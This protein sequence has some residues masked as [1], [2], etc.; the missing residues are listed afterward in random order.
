MHFLTLITAMLTGVV[1]GAW[2]SSSLD[3]IDDLTRPMTLVIAIK[4]RGLDELRT[5]VDTVSDPHSASYGKYLTRDQVGAMVRNDE[6]Y[7]AVV[8]ALATVP[9]RVVR[10][11]EH[12]EYII[13]EAPAAVWM[14]FLDVASLLDLDLDLKVP[15]LL[16]QHVLAIFD[17]SHRLPAGRAALHTSLAGVRPDV[18]TPQLLQTYYGIPSGP[19]DSSSSETTQG[20]YEI[21][22]HQPI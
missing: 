6:S 12:K 11:T 18:V 5:I 7:N 22:F 21:L 8:A 14:A 3:S 19:A 15:R 9:I 20:V 10:S 2:A 4:Q 1:F 16:H 13:A 17:L